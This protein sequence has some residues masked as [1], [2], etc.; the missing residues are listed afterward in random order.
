MRTLLGVFHSRERGRAARDQFARAGY[1]VQLIDQPESAADLAQRV[2]ESGGEGRSSSSASGAT[3][4]GLAGGG[5]GAVPGAILGRVV[6]NW[7]TQQRTQ[8]YEQDIANGGA[9]L[10]VHAEELM[11]AANA[12][13]MLYQVGADHVENGERPV[14]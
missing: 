9:A 12:E 11:P 1:E 6:G 13:S 14:S 3:L 2:S 10:I 7:L 4:G 8:E 5:I